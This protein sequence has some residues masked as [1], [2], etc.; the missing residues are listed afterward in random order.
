MKKLVLA[1]LMFCMLVASPTMAQITVEEPVAEVTQP[2]PTL[3]EVA[4][5]L[6]YDWVVNPWDGNF[7]IKHGVGLKLLDFYGGVA[8]LRV[9]W[10]PTEVLEDEDAKKFIGG[11]IGVDVLRGI[12]MIVE[13]TGMEIT[14]PDFVKLLNPSLGLLWMAN[15]NNGVEMPKWDEPWVMANVV[16]Y[17]FKNIPFLE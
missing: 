13:K 4:P 10:I 14:V 1:L 16:N 12:G 6:S 17:K 5:A 11:G 9:E 7:D 15:L 3:V 8:N 2:A